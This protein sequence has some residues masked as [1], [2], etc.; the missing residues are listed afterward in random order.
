MFCEE[1][2]KPFFMTLVGRPSC[3]AVTEKDYG[4]FGLLLH[5]LRHNALFLTCD[6]EVE[7]VSCEVRNCVI[8]LQV[9]RGA[10]LPAPPTLL[11]CSMPSTTHVKTNTLI[12]HDSL[13]NF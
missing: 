11:P 6:L 1:V 7:P 10:D 8:I 4:W 9:L 13:P 5:G 3:E 2:A 12:S